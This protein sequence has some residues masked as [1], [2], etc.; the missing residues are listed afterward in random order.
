MNAYLPRKDLNGFLALLAKNARVTVPVRQ[1]K[2]I[3]FAPYAE[4]T[5]PELKRSTVSP[6]SVALPQCETL[7][8]YSRAKDPENPGHVSLRL[9]DHKDA[10]PTVVFG[11]RP[12]DAAG[13]AVLDR[14]Y[15]RGP[16]KDPYYAARR[17]NLTVITQSCDAGCATC[18]CNWTGGGPDSP[19]GSDILFTAVEDGFW[20]EA[21][22]AKG[23]AL[24]KAANLADGKDKEAEALAK[25]ESGRNSMPEA[26]DL[27]KAGELIAARFT[28]NEF[29]Q[30]TTA[31][32]LGC[33]AC[34]YFCPTCYCFTIT[35][36][37]EGLGDIPGRRMRSWDTCMG[38]QFTREASGHNPRGLK[39]NR[40]RNR[41]SHKF[42]FYPSVWE[43]AFSC[44]GCGRCI[45]GCPVHVDIRAMVLA[46]M[47]PRQEGE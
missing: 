33:G 17:A 26:P 41:V 36:E 40:M 3:V 2:A 15:L 38:S 23:E 28:D 32:C 6:K 1:G 16:H 5:V 7:V 34:T 24:L 37:G 46:A 22:S 12:C 4:G 13:F 25:R 29:W 27:G 30:K 21:V 14:P 8:S 19:T 10:S 18:F 43:G 31:H 47:K 42:S 45:A 11:C 39:A 35:D 44:S 20:L 9:E